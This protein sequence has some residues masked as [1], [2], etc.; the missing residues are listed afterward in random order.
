MGLLLS[1]IAR[2]RGAK[3]KYIHGPLQNHL[4]LNEGIENLEIKTSRELAYAI[5]KEIS[6]YDFFV[7]NAAVSDF[8][9]CGDA[10]KKIPKKQFEDY[11]QSN[12]EMVPDILN[13]VSKFKKQNQVFVG[14]CAFTGPINKARDSINKKMINKGCDLLFANPIDI[15]GQGFGSSAEN[16]GW[17]FNKKN[18]ELHIEKTSKIELAN[19]LINEIISINK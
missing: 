18:M 7:M 19:R 17:L 6:D 15:E 12:I 13:Q 3:V 14:F 8:R 10:S 4:H 2:F 1:Q 9:I 16:E 5:Q 11:L